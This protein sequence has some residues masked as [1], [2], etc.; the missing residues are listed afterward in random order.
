MSS[1]IATPPSRSSTGRRIRLELAGAAAEQGHGA[2]ALTDHDGLHGAM[3]MA[4]A[5]KPLGRAADHRR[6][7]HARRRHPP[8]A[9]VRDARG[10]H[11]PLPAAHRVALATRRWAREGWTEGGGRQDP[12]DASRASRSRRWSSTPT[13][14]SA[15]RA[16]RATARWPRA[17]RRATH[18]GA[19]AVARRLLRVF[20][21]DA[22]PRRAPAPLR[23]PRPAP[24]PAARRAGRA[25]RGALRRHRQRARARARA[26][27]AP[28]RDGGGAARQD[29][30]RDRA[31]AGAA[32]PR[33]CSP[34]PRGWPSASASIPDAVEESGR[35]AERL[36]LRPHR[37][38]RLPLPR[39]GGPGGRPKLAELCRRRFEERYGRRDSRGGARGSTRSCA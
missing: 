14:S 23:A 31:A 5:L 10:L 27:R 34:R 8:H 18:A 39:L 28:G 29:A 3:E 2:L 1:S 11:E 33:T 13:G 38:P 9:P 15:C 36:C 26:D 32:T 37:G 16:A 25:A 7:A 24:Q 20:G 22:L 17:W 4:Q 6:R 35:L 21:P 19:A 30:R 12:L